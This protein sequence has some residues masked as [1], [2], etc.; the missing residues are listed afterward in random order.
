M[1]CNSKQNTITHLQKVGV[2]D[3]YGRVTNPS[4]LDAIN[5]HYMT[6]IADTYGIVPE[7][8]VLLTSR[9]ITR[10]DG[11]S[12]SNTKS[13]HVLETNDAAFEQINEAINDNQELLDE[14]IDYFEELYAPSSPPLVTPAYEKSIQYKKNLL[15]R[16]E[17]RL[18]K[19]KADKREA[20]SDLVLLKELIALENAIEARIE[21][22]HDLEITGLRAEIIDLESDPPI[23]KF[24]FYAE[25]DFER[26]EALVDSENPEDL[27]EARTIIDFYKAMGDFS[28]KVIHPL[29]NET[30][31]VM[32]NG[33][34][35][36]TYYNTG[37][38]EDSG[39]LVISQEIQ[40]KLQE[41]SLRAGEKERKLYEKEKQAIVSNV[42]QNTKVQGLYS[43]EFTHDELFFK[44]T[45]LKDTPWIDMFL[46]DITNGI[47]ST[48]GIIPQ[49]MMNNIQNAFEENLVKAKSV[50]NRLN[51]MQPQ[52]EAALK[53]LGYDLA[54]T[55]GVFGLT[56]VSYDLFKAEDSNG[57]FKDGIVQRYDSSFTDSKSG[58][59][60]TFNR[61]FAAA[62]K[63]E[64][65]AKKQEAIKAAYIKKRNWFKKNTIVID[66]NR[67]TDLNYQ[68]ELEDVLGPQGYVE[69]MAKQ[70]K[71]IRDYEVSLEIYKDQVIAEGGASTIQANKIER[72][73][74]RN[75]PYEATTSYYDN[76]PITIG[77][78]T[79]ES[80]MKY[81]SAI[82]RRTKVLLRAGPHGLSAAATPDDTGFYDKKFETIENNPVLK[83]FH[84]LTMEVQQMITE[85]MPIDVRRKFSANSLPSL[86]KNLIEILT[87][88]NIAFLAKISKA[89]RH[90]IDKIMGAFGM[91]IQSSLSNATIDPI[92]GKPEYKVNSE[93]LK[94]NKEEINKR[95]QIEILRLKRAI[96]MRLTATITDRTTF[97][98]TTASPDAIDIIAEALGVDSTLAAIKARI[99]GDMKV[100][101]IGKMLRSGITHQVVQEKSFDLPKI[102]KLY[103]YMTMEYAARQEALPLMEIMKSHYE[104]IKD[105]ALTNT[106]ASMTNV[107]NQETTLEGVRVGAI[108]QMNSWFDRVILG[109]YG[110]KNE[111]GDTTLKRNIKLGFSEEDQTNIFKSMVST[112]ITGRI[113]NTQEKIIAKKLP[114]LI[115]EAQSLVDTAPNP[116]LQKQAQKVLSNL[117]YTQDNLG[118][119]F[120]VTKMFDAIFNFIRLKGLGWNLSSSVTNFMEGQIANITIAATGDYFTPE[121]IYRA[122]GIIKGSFMKTLAMGKYSTNGAKLTRTL[123]DRYRVLQDASNE[124]QKAS[125]KSAFSKFQNLDPYEITR[126]TEYLN[127]GPLMIAILMDQK[128]T[129]TDGTVSN[130]WDAM[131]PDGTLKDNFRSESNIANWENADG[132]QYNDF[133]THL[134]KTIVNAHGDYDELRGNMAT[135][136]ISGKALLM[137]KRWM[138]KQ[139]YQ[140]FAMVEQPDLEVG[141][142]EYK[143]RYLS[144]TKSTGFTHGAIIGFSAFG[145]LGAGPLGFLIGGA[146]GFATAQGFGAN[147]GINFLKEL[148]FT[149][150][151]LFLNLVR[152]PINNTMGREVVTDLGLNKLFVKAGLP[153]TYASLKLEERDM[154]NY[155]ANMIDMSMTLAWMG[156]ML[157][158]KALLWDDE[159]DSEDPRRKAHNLLANRFMQLAGAATMYTNPVEAWGSTVGN[160]PVITFFTDVGKLANAASGAFSDD[161]ILASGPNAGQSK[162]GNQFEKT[163]YPGVVKGGVGFEKAMNRQFRPHAFDSWFHSDEKKAKK[164]TK[165][166][167]AQALNGHL[168][169]GMSK[170]DAKKA[171]KKKYRYKKKDETYL[172]LL[173]VYKNF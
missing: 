7:S 97:D 93:F 172:D 10:Q 138:G 131:N 55:A 26:L 64:D 47:F 120:S 173:K 148:A 94:S 40:D 58:M 4:R 3:E 71:L 147:T 30:K 61:D 84:N 119:H 57:Q 162:F 18:E 43:E 118:K 163:F 124:L 20:S 145:L 24:E 38:N 102:L 74:K 103:S 52:V 54:G 116:E 19:I 53:A 28:P 143:G 62:L 87:S 169:D 34:M 17:G 21:G 6:H 92:T 31:D 150:K 160:L 132:Q 152:I 5:A 142:K 104:E 33:K 135:E 111:L 51:E 32:Q 46:M 50:E 165:A 11:T 100:A 153:S 136:T 60:Y 117:V 70:S 29:Y 8:G 96:G 155:K 16:L 23:A 89:Y 59:Y 154:R 166:I 157:F 42:N 158:T 9:E 35:V 88:P 72:W 39:V 77:A 113:L 95:Y 82:P 109:E 122:N 141:I 151:E 146:A 90:L 127:Q 156:L 13:F 44:N 67:L 137:F 15:N 65:P 133:A 139:F 25:K 126:R 45:G 115:I 41:L 22:V 101:E 164:V 86:E 36:K 73:T 144:H 130:V 91:N 123:M 106:G 125:S 63:I 129:G 110:S 167:R 140:R 81:N 80:S 159:D 2:L 75:S 37:F 99:P 48:N 83:E 27:K 79:L 168:L 171:V 121:N 49:V 14:P 78:K 128:I 1:A 68:K 105:P 134:K 107:A 108:R 76:T 85:V 114:A 56:G 112:T 170:E 149:S 12:R 69:E 66:V 161:D 98:L